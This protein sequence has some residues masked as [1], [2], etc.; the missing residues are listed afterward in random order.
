MKSDVSTPVYINS[1]TVRMFSFVFRFFFFDNLWLCCHVG[2]DCYLLK[3]SNLRLFLIP[4]CIVFSPSF[5]TTHFH[6][7]YVFRLTYLNPSILVINSNC[8]FIHPVLGVSEIPTLPTG[9]TVGVSLM[10]VRLMSDWS[11]H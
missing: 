8:I 1:E 7:N 6:T 3:I 9:H 10:I 2:I 5:Q 11:T 4:T